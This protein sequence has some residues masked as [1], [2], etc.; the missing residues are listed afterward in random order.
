MSTLNKNR[1]KNWH[2]ANCFGYAL[3]YNHWLGFDSDYCDAADELMSRFPNLC[4]V[5]KDEMVLGK[6][7]IA[8]RYGREDFHFMKRGKKG[9]WT[10]KP[11]CYPVETISTK[12]VFAA[13]WSNEDGDIY[14][15]RIYLFEIVGN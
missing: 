1:N 7:Y 14:N 3:G 8:F 5:S 15:S 13:E 2:Y 11:G 10:H 12:D 4:P 6:E 9:H